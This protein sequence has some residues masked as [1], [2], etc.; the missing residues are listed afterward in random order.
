MKSLV[1]RLQSEEFP[2]VRIGTGFCDNKSDLINYVINKVTN[3]EYNNLLEGINKAT[4]AICGII[5]NGID[6]TMNKFN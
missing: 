3:E 2:R 6:V 5:K 4:D 1:Y